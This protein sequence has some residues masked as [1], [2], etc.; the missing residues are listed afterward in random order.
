[1]AAALLTTPSLTHAQGGCGFTF[2]A[3]VK[4]PRCFGICDGHIIITPDTPGAWYGFQ[5]SNGST[6]NSIYN[7]CEDEYTVTITDDKG[8]S[9]TVTYTIDEPDQMVTACTVIQNE[10]TPGAADGIIEASATGGTL[11]YTFEWQVSPVVYG[12]TL[13]GLSAGTYFVMGYDANDCPASSYCAVYT[14]KKE[15]CDGFR[16]Q[17]QGGWGQCQQNG[18]NP[19]T[20]LF[21]NFAGAFP[22]GLTIGCNRTLKLTSAQAVCDFLPSGTSPKVL[23]AGHKVNPGSTYSNVFAG[24]LVAATLNVQFDMYDASFG[25]SGTNLGDMIINSGAFTGWSVNELLDEANRKIGGC[26][27]PYS[28]SALSSALDAINNNY[29]DGTVD[30][31]FLVCPEDK[32]DK[33]LVTETVKM[34]VMPN[35]VSD[36]A[37]L[38]IVTA[39]DEVAEAALFTVSGQKVLS[40]FKGSVT[41]G[42]KVEVAFETSSLNA[43][44]YF[45]QIKTGAEVHT[46]KL[47]IRK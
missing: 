29:T 14:D 3:E 33:V 17:T 30:N 2:K 31:G 41:A 47:V 26:A 34:T 6:S 25:A 16:T 44:I 10:S 32:K 42:E 18:N 9:E 4:Q 20:Y 8:C 19:G 40:I 1:M 43:G 45:L 23:P 37:T 15:K 7:L 24:Q 36:R 27:S 39:N 35:P 21:A 46:Q 28:A 13:S 12:N 38:S 22:N 11:P 5:W